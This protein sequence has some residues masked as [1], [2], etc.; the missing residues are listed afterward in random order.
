MEDVLGDCCDDCPVPQTSDEKIT[1][2][3][4]DKIFVSG[5][6]TLSRSGPLRQREEVLRPRTRE[7]YTQQAYVGVTDPLCHAI[8][9]CNLSLVQSLL[10]RGGDD[11][12]GRDINGR[13]PLHLAS[14]CS[15]VDIVQCLLEHGAYLVPRQK[16]GKAAID[17]ACIRG[18]VD[19]VSVLLRQDAKNRDRFNAGHDNCDTVPGD[20]E[21]DDINVPFSQHE[22]LISPLH[23]AVSYNNLS[24]VEN[25]VQEWNADIHQRMEMV[26][27]SLNRGDAH[28]YG[29]ERYLTPLALALRLPLDAA[30]R[31]TRLLFKLGASSEEKVDEYV[32]VL[33]ACITSRPA[34]LDTYFD[35]D[36]EGTVR[37]TSAIFTKGQRVA[38][39]RPGLGYGKP[40]DC[41]VSTPLLTAIQARDTTTATRLLEMGAKATLPFEAFAHVLNSKTEFLTT[42]AQPVIVAVEEELP[43][44]AI[45]LIR[46]Y[47]ADVNTLTPNGWK[48]AHES[49]LLGT[50]VPESLLNCVD[51]RIES[52]RSWIQAPHEPRYKKEVKVER[53]P[54]REN[55]FYLG[56]HAKDTYSY[57]SY[58]LML[59]RER[60]RLERFHGTPAQSRSTQ[61]LEAGFKEKLTAIESIL[62]A[63]LVLKDLLDERSAK[64]FRDLH[65]QFAVQDQSPSS[66]RTGSHSRPWKPEIRH[67]YSVPSNYGSHPTSY[68]NYRPDNYVGLFEAVWRGDI[69]RVKSLTLLPG[70]DPTGTSCPPLTIAVADLHQDSPFTIALSRG[71]LELARAIY[72]IAEA[73]YQPSIHWKRTAKRSASDSGHSADDDD[74]ESDVEESEFDESEETTDDESELD[75]S[76]QEGSVDGSDFV[77]SK[78]SPAAGLSARKPGELAAL[79]ADDDISIDDVRRVE[80]S[81]ANPV[82]PALMFTWRCPKTIER[83]NKDDASDSIGRQEILPRNMTAMALFHNDLDML[84]CLLDLAEEPIKTA[85]DRQGEEVKP[86]NSHAV[87]DH[88]FRVALQSANSTTLAMLIERTAAG[89]PLDELSGESQLQVSTEKAGQCRGLKTGKVRAQDASRSVQSKRPKNSDRISP[90]LLHAANLGSF[91]NLQWLLSDAPLEHYRQYATENP[92]DHRVRQI[93]QSPEGFGGIVKSFLGSRSELAIICCVMS[94]SGSEG[95]EILSHL[96]KIMPDAVNARSSAGDTPLLIAYRF[97]NLQAA[98]LL[99]KAG[100]DQTARDHRGGNVLHCLFDMFTNAGGG[101]G[102]SYVPEVANEK[103]YVHMRAMMDLLDE[104]LLPIICTQRHHASDY[105]WYT[106]LASLLYH[107]CT[108]NSFLVATARMILEYSKGAELGLLDN[109]GNTPLHLLVYKNTPPTH[110]D[111]Y[112][113]A[114][115]IMEFRPDL[116]NLENTSGKTP[117]DMAQDGALRAMCKGRN[118][119]RKYGQQDWRPLYTTHEYYT[120]GFSVTCTPEKAFTKPE[121]DYDDFGGHDMA[122]L[123]LS[124]EID[125]SPSKDQR[126]VSLYRLLAETKAKLD[127]E[128]K[129]K[130]IVTSVSEV[131]AAADMDN[132]EKLHQQHDDGYLAET[133][134]WLNHELQ[135]RLIRAQFPGCDCSFCLRFCIS[136]PSPESL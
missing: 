124:G 16:D 88:A 100:A 13:T 108:P 36:F 84:S 69:A 135:Q 46:E 67:S 103:H 99:I 35:A 65:P 64:L 97:Q 50:D 37:S 113:V 95:L 39:S 21:F 119:L 32:S 34:L 51:R 122:R 92:N 75:E 53:E 102:S 70:Q 115:L 136:V 62:N 3:Q 98:K 48:A 60:E 22:I 8:A 101:N 28:Y 56:D 43:L 78:S 105:R 72:L 118:S 6:M 93:S 25:L 12:N 57:C 77:A 41:V 83:R 10:G 129:G 120:V 76:E 54:M 61:S 73:Q 110:F 15:T 90:P 38:Q 130:R 91:A 96:I 52:L 63:F 123:L 18:D 24:L 128:G 9:D 33:Q 59:D 29:L 134:L 27:G 116:V 94:K 82:S 85:F 26:E 19:I 2:R 114:A 11:I 1:V 107:A 127:R 20:R 42:V 132:T 31:M 68:S 112:G 7:D 30:Q 133:D 125:P 104:D 47:D 117:L 45:A 14:A 81:V 111:F 89:V 23:L 87:D 4:N 74:T 40:G 80:T 71:H 66:D 106:P 109:E 49:A 17:I 79:L 86:G 58:D 5:T 126:I 44:L 121:I 55:A 131:R